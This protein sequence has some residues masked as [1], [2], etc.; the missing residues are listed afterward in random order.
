[1]NS[2]SKTIGLVVP[3]ITDPFFS[4]LIKGIDEILRIKGYSTIL[5]DSDSNTE[6]EKQH[7]ETLISKNVDGILLIPYIEHDDYAEQLVS[8]GFPIVFVDRI[9]SR[10]DISYV[11]TNNREGGFQATKYLLQLGHRKI[12]FFSNPITKRPPTRERFYGYKQALS[13]AGIEIDESLIL[14]TGTQLEKACSDIAQSLVQGKSDFTAIFAAYDSWAFEVMKA[15]SRV[16]I[17]I[18]EQISIIGFDDIPFSSVIPPAPSII[19]DGLN[20]CNIFGTVGPSMQL[21]E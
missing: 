11:T 18:P 7:L 16:N 21:F 2:L 9:T 1:M 15:L 3:E 14:Q 20:S 10:E 5:C 8:E 4:L 6:Y 19:L 13:E 17:L 12:L